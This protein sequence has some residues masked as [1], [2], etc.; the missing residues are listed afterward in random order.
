MARR[1][2]WLLFAVA[3]A[4]FV[5]VA[6]GVTAWGLGLRAAR[7]FDSAI[8]AIDR[9]KV[10]GAG[11]DTL[12]SR[13]DA[14]AELAS[15]DRDWLR[16]LKRSSGY[17]D[18][19]TRLRIARAAMSKSRGTPELRTV[20]VYET[21]RAG[22]PDATA[23]LPPDYTPIGPL[24]TELDLE[25]SLAAVPTLPPL[26]TVPSNGDEPLE[27]NEVPQTF[28]QNGRAGGAQLS[29]LL[30]TPGVAVPDPTD[31]A[32]HSDALSPADQVR[33]CLLL[34]DYVGAQTIVRE[35]VPTGGFGHPDELRL[36]AETY[37]LAGEYMYAGDLYEGLSA[38]SHGTADDAWNAALLL[39]DPYTW[40]ET[41]TADDVAISRAPY[42]DS[43]RPSLTAW[44]ILTN[45][46]V[47]AIP[48]F[49]RDTRRG[50]PRFPFY[51]ALLHLRIGDYARAID[52][53]RRLFTT[54]PDLFLAY[55]LAAAGVA[56]GRDIP[57]G[58]VRF[59]NDPCLCESGLFWYLPPCTPSSH[60][61]YE[62]LCLLLAEDAARRG[63]H[64]EAHHWANTVLE[65]SP[66]NGEARRI[67]RMDG[68]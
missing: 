40:E 27:P 24:S 57:E 23:H 7:A 50:D 31:Q 52:E 45:D 49:L 25:R 18:P 26:T 10:A 65:V 12:I 4:A 21:L 59:A 28:A 32:D 9:A 41:G 53:L 11:I 48:L 36:E 19:A 30:V 68:R 1:R 38:G 8:R 39:G 14:A 44:R 6:V 20:V 54:A 67:L 58:V 34:G 29:G 22:G 51:S 42:G 13:I 2:E 43:E 33:I 61:V 60:Y 47:A 5:G 55:H 3:L 15:R 66:A 64:E 37:L 62:R 16:V 46:N 63:D 17:A 56:L 35:A